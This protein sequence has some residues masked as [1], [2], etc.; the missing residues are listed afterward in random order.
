MPPQE[1][2]AATQLTTTVLV[3]EGD[4]VWEKTCLAH[5]QF[6][7]HLTGDSHNANACAITMHNALSEVV[8]RLSGFT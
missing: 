4:G 5:I 7:Y 3:T 2:N 8:S 1:Y 6:P